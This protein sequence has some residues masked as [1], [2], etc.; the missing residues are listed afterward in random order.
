[1]AGKFNDPEALF[2]KRREESRHG[3]RDDRE[4]EKP[5]WRELDRKRDRGGGGEKREPLDRYQDAAA[6]KVLKE[7]LGALFEDKEATELRKKLLAADRA[8]L[9][10]AVAAWV[11]AKGSFPSDDP[12]LLAKALDVRKAAHLLLVV[13]A[14]GQHL[15]CTDDVHKKM[16]MLKLRGKSRTVF[17]RKVSSRIRQVLTEHSKDS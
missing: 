9:G 1:M 12:E 8:G 7:Q 6:Q 2:D 5:S 14:V 3:K 16:F 4:R 17:D 10:E 15:T 13:D 11:D